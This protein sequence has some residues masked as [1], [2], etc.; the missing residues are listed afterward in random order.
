MYQITDKNMPIPYTQYTGPGV[1]THDGE[2]AFSEGS[3]ICTPHITN[4]YF[5]CLFLHFQT[6]SEGMADK[7]I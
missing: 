3:S 7:K 1:K 5:R 4:R 6:L 2:A